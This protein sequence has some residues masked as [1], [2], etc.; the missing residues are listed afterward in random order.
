[1]VLPAVV[2]TGVFVSSDVEEASVDVTG[3][4]VM[5]VVSFLGDT[6]DNV[7]VV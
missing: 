7:D 3:D 5:L 1:M 2:K 6:V 4:S